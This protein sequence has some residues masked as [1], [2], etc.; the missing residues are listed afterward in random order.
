ME[1][2]KSEQYISEKLN[3]Q[4]VSKDRLAELCKEPEFDD[5]TKQFIE[6]SNLIWNTSTR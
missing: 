4:P 5:K 3:I 2:L 6:D 1:I